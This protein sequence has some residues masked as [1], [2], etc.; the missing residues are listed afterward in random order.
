MEPARA[1]VEVRVPEKHA[2]PASLPPLNTCGTPNMQ[3]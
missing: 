3:N 1:G 2:L